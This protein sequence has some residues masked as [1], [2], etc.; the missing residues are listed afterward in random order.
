MY[1][2]GA[3]KP[4]ERHMNSGYVIRTS[5]DRANGAGGKHDTPQHPR[6]DQRRSTEREF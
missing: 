4:R 1:A 6:L 3:T 2:A 5:P